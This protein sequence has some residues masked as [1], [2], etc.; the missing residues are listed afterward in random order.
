LKRS[1]T[2]IGSEVAAH[3]SE[4]GE[5]IVEREQV[6]EGTE[7][8]GDEAEGAV[9]M[10]VGHRGLDELGAALDGGGLGGKVGAADGEHAGGQIEAGD[11]DPGTRGGD[12]DAA[13]AASKFEDGTARFAGSVDIE[14]DISERAV[15][16]H[17]IVEVGDGSVFVWEH[18]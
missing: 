3:A 4:A 2:A 15:W 7:R 11:L 10:E 14:T 16:G 1:N 8:N 12:E 5:L 9:E 13:G 6:L 18:G 17:V